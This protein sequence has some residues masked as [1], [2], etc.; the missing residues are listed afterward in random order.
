MKHIQTEVLPIEGLFKQIRKEVYETANQLPWE[1]SCLIEDFCFNYGQ[2]NP[3]FEL[4]YSFEALADKTIF[5]QLLAQKNNR[6][7]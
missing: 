7:V 6:I 1:H 3:S 2:N 5:L 4:P